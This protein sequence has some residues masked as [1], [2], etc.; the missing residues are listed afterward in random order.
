MP[1]EFAS[2]PAPEVA[3]ALAVLAAL[4]RLKNLTLHRPFLHPCE[5]AS[6]VLPNLETLHLVSPSFPAA[7]AAALVFALVKSAPALT[8]FKVSQWLGELGS[9]LFFLGQLPKLREVTI[10]V[11]G[12]DNPAEVVSVSQALGSLRRAH[13]ALRV[14]VVGL[15]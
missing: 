10:D 3:A 6:F 1:A 15:R 14:K 12:V 11:T 9:A 13:P 5:A 2:E 8:A 4:P 7:S